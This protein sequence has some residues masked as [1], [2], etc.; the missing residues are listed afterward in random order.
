[1]EVT[2]MPDKAPVLRLQHFAVQP[3]FVFDDGDELTPGPNV[4]PIQ[5]TLAGLRDLLERWP[6]HLAALQDG[7]PTA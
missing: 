5:V 1:M 4:N 3:V 7:T 2:P 6:E